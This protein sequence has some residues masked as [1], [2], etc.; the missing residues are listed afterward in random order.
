VAQFATVAALASLIPSSNLRRAG[1]LRFRRG[2]ELE[3]V[4]AFVPFFQRQLRIVAEDLS[5]ATPIQLA[6][7][8]VAGDAQRLRTLPPLELDAVVTSPPYLNGTNYFRNTKVELW[9]LRSI[10]SG[11]DL[12]AFRRLSV[13]A[14]INDVTRQKPGSKHPVVRRV[15]EALERTAY[16]RRIPQM[17][18]NYF[19]DMECALGGLAPHLLPDAVLALDIGD[20]IYAN[21]H[22]PTDRLIAEIA[23][24][25][26]FN[27]E[28]SLLLRSR[29]SRDTSPLKQVL[30]IFRFRPP[31]ACRPSPPAS[32]PAWSDRWG[33]FKRDLPHQAQPFAKRNW[34]HPLHSLCSYQGKMKPSLAHHLV[35]TF[36]PAGGRMLDPF[37]GVG[38]IPFEAALQGAT[39]F[40][41]EISPAAVVI[42]GAKLG[43]ARRKEVEVTLSALAE[44]LASAKPSMQERLSAKEIRFNSGIDEYFHP[45]TLEEVLLARRFFRLHPPCSASE[46]LVMASLLHI[47]HGNRP[48]ALSRRSHPITPFSPTGSKEYRPLITR[49]REKVERSLEA[50]LP[51]EFVEEKIFECDATSWW[52]Q[53][54]DQLDA[55]V[56]SPPF[57]DSTRFHLANWMRLW[58]AGWERADFDARP[59]SFVDERQKVSFRVYEPI[60][61]QARERLRPGG[62]FVLHLGWSA[63]CDM[64]A[65]IKEV[66]APWFRVADRFSESVEHCES[67]GI[68]D[69]GTVTAHQFLVLQ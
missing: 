48:Y 35:R 30:L 61:R 14:G 59:R 20:S 4:E 9:F 31:A 47:L 19:H 53:E 7:V 13:T 63:K 45:R 56:T 28:Q 32:R 38:T 24:P 18:S 41:F 26:G 6:P 43:R 16:D 49:L 11:D 34:G 21:T 69:K 65:R 12:A 60:F 27:L 55:V 52:P 51:P 66:A 15:V 22:V 2:K 58:F 37:A 62:V 39:A 57:F 64:A 33:S 5:A 8:L 25:L 40:G 68:R 17:V 67:H 3:E 10:W 42:A 1:D 29:V 44:L 23:E 54:V 46:R 36:V 50:V